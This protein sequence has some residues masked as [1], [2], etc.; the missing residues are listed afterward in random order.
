MAELTQS[1]QDHVGFGGRGKEAVA[2]VIGFPLECWEAGPF[3]PGGVWLHQS[4][5]SSFSLVLQ[6]A[7]STY[8]F[9]HSSTHR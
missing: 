5:S 4:C 3:Q 2:A 8:I 1:L 6:S 7:T 9:T